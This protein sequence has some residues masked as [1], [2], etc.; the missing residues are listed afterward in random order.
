[1]DAVACA[2]RSHFSIHLENRAEDC[3]RVKQY[4]MIA[5]CSSV[6]ARDLLTLGLGTPACALGKKKYAAWLP[7]QDKLLVAFV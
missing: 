5:D 2:E 4:L 3:R 6:S 7:P 1:M